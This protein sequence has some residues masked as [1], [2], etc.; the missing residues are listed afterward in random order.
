MIL[1]QDQIVAIEYRFWGVVCGIDYT[2]V[3]VQFTILD[4]IR[5]NMIYK[6]QRQMFNIHYDYT[7]SIH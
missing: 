6:L 5:D 4:H 7:P 2:K 1:N 3:S